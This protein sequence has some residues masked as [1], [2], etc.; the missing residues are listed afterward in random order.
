V[1]STTIIEMA[2]EEQAH[3]LAAVRRARPGDVLA[4]QLLLLGAAQQT[5]TEIA[6]VLYCSR[7]P[8][9]RVVKAYRA[10]PGGVGAGRG[11]WASGSPPATDGARA[12]AP[13]RRAGPCEQR[14]APVWGVSDAVEVRPDCVGTPGPA[15]GRGVR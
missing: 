4:L 12:R 10:G 14:A 11:A 1:P 7:T 3:I 8:V 15:R 13:A 2:P 5:P 6:A 9:Y